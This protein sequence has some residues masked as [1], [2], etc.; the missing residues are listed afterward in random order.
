MKKIGLLLIIFFSFI[1]TNVSAENL[2]CGVDENNQIITYSFDVCSNDISLNMTYSLLGFLYDE[3]VFPFGYT[4]FV[5]TEKIRENQSSYSDYYKRFGIIF[6]DIFISMNYIT[7]VILYLLIPYYVLSGLVNSAGGDFL[8]DTDKAGT[9]KRIAIGIFLLVPIK[10][11]TIAQI[12]ILNLS[13]FSIAGANFILSGF[14]SFLQNSIPEIS[15]VGEFDY[16]IDSV[17]ENSIYWDYALLDVK[18]ATKMALCRNRTSEYLL[19]KQLHVGDNM[20]EFINCNSPSPSSISTNIINNEEINLTN[21]SS[22]INYNVYDEKNNN[23]ISSKL[24]FG[25]NLTEQCNTDNTYKFYCGEIVFPSFNIQLEN[26]KLNKYELDK[27]I[28]SDA[29]HIDLSY[30]INQNIYEKWEKFWKEIESSDST[31]V[32]KIVNIVDE[33]KKDKNDF[34]DLSIV[35]QRNN[36]KIVSYYYHQ[37]IQNHLLNGIIYGKKKVEKDESFLS[38][39]WGSDDITKIEI[40]NKEKLKIQEKMDLVNNIAK[41]IETIECMDDGID[42]V[43]TQ[44]AYNKIKNN[45]NSSNVRAKC[46]YFDN[47]KN[48]EVL[49]L[50]DGK[51]PVAK[52]KDEE[53]EI[54]KLTNNKIKEIIDNTEIDIRK[55]ANKIYLIKK[56]TMN[57]FNKSIRMTR[58]DGSNEKYFNEDVLIQARQLGWG[59]FGSLIRRVTE[60]TEAESKLQKALLTGLVYN[61]TMENNMVSSSVLQEGLKYPNLNKEIQMMFNSFYNNRKLKKIENLSLTKYID[62]YIEQEQDNFQGSSEEVSLDL[63]FD[64][65]NVLTNNVNQFNISMGI[66]STGINTDSKTNNELTECIKGNNTCGVPLIHPMHSINKLGKDIISFTSGLFAAS[67]SIYTSS[68]LIDNKQK[69]KKDNDGKIKE[70]KKNKAKKDF[71]K[72]KEFSKLPSF[73]GKFIGG[74]IFTFIISMF[75]SLFAL[76]AATGVFFAYILPLIPFFIFVMALIGWIVLLFQILIISNIWVALLFQPKNR[77]ENTEGINAI[78]NAVA[79]LMLR[80]ALV[81]TSLILAWSLFTILIIIVNLTVGPL[82]S[83]IS[84]TQHLFGI[85]DITFTLTF[86]AIIIYIVTQISFKMINELPKKVFASMNISAISEEDDLMES[87]TKTATTL[88]TFS[89]IN[90]LT[91]YSN[92]KQRNLNQNKKAKTKEDKEND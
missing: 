5:D 2:N 74:D 34:S 85:I 91:G 79:Q 67:I 55:M 78:K 69:N 17:D 18:K 56:G 77:G 42:L 28:I 75:S 47:N 76:L 16:K 81:T 45:I 65:I 61:E 57:S 63:F 1:S 52:T 68:L 43:K 35:S 83:K 36:K 46:L 23:L 54:L 26:V 70:G 32:E 60:E 12:L 48:T 11:I 92:Q 38:F 49:G 73:F 15:E 6:N 88:L 20:D 25:N 89:V 58:Q 50:I 3:Y 87:L 29:E 13:L 21:N 51:I 39:I 27:R 86:Y 40:E 22:F 9:A 44:N 19:E 72:S 37:T 31:I 59:G 53:K 64:I 84:E 14:L 82:L 62:S 90:K 7:L 24:F 33:N 30:T 80:P 41:N 4:K 10:G 8:G 71:K 66:N